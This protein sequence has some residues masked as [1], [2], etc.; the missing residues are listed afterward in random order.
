MPDLEARV[1]RTIG[2]PDIRFREDPVRILRAV[3]FAARC[4][5][6]IEPETYRRMMEHRLEIAKC[7]Q[8]RVSE[9]FY[10]LLRAGA[11]KRSMELLLETELLEILAPELVRG[12]KGDADADEA[13]LRRARLLGLPGRAR[14]LVGACARCRRR[15]RCCWRCWCCRALRDAL[16]PDSNG[17]RDIGQLVGAGR[18]RRR[19]TGC[20]RRAATA[21]SRARSCSRSATSCPSKSG[22]PEAAAAVA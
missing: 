18:S 4:D 17:V 1:V 12:L 14:S 10:R 19:S 21:S 16:D 5:L 9:E 13:A 8:A 11:A 7:A 2:D 20:G 3:K 15:T 6:T 22:A